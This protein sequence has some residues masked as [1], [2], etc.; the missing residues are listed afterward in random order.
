MVEG[1]DMCVEKGPVLARRLIHDYLMAL[2]SPPLKPVIS[3]W[4][5]SITLWYTG[6][7]I[8]ER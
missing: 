6:K 8:G 3:R 4:K 2:P 5:V 7:W 1:K